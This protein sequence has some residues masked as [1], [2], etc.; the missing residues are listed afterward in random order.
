MWVAVATRFSVPMDNENGDV[1][2][3]SYV[4]ILKRHDQLSS[5]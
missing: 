5:A 3:D 2:I 4:K 1:A